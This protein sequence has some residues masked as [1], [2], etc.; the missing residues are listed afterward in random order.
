MVCNILVL[1]LFLEHFIMGLR[2]ELGLNLV[3]ALGNI[4]LLL[5]YL[6]NLEIRM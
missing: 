5:I 6:A 1:K 3:D 2:V 4:L